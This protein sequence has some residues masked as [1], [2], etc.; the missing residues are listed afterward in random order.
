[1]SCDHLSLF[2]ILY[3][4]LLHWVVNCELWVVTTWQ[5]LSLLQSIPCPTPLAHWPKAPPWLDNRDIPPPHDRLIQF[6]FVIVFPLVF[7]VFEFG[8]TGS[9]HDWANTPLTQVAAAK[10]AKGQLVKHLTIPRCHFCAHLTRAQYFVLWQIKYLFSKLNGR[11]SFPVPCHSCYKN[12]EMVV[13]YFKVGWIG[14]KSKK[15]SSEEH[16]IYGPGSNL[17]VFQL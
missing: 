17:N 13:N 12:V 14:W 10:A 16:L 11:V 3:F 1:M 6:V 4:Y 5:P 9:H 15:R 8:T 7:S 2:N